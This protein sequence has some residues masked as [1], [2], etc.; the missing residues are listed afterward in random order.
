MTNNFWSELGLEPTADLRSIRHA[1]AARAK[2]CH[3]EEAPEEFQR[4][5]DAYEAALSW[6]KRHPD[7]VPVQKDSDFPPPEA[8]PPAGPDPEDAEL[9]RLIAS[10]LQKEAQRKLTRYGRALGSLYHLSRSPQARD[11]LPSW[12]ALLDSQDFSS[13]REEPEF[14]PFLQQFLSDHYETLPDA[15][16]PALRDAFNL[17]AAAV[18]PETEELYKLVLPRCKQ[19]SQ[20]ENSPSR[21]QPKQ[22]VSEAW[23]WALAALSVLILRNVE[24]SPIFLLIPAVPALALLLVRIHRKRSP[25]SSRKR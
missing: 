13:L 14:Y 23:L 12:L 3:P 10:G 2:D 1:Y 25:K 21:K 16:W 6:A 7:G 18:T 17:S 5:H 11:A 20:K 4:L 8:P 15:A 9:D 24:A 22:A 19:L